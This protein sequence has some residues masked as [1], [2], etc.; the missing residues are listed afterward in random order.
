M[1]AEI[2]FGLKWLLIKGKCCNSFQKI[3]LD[4]TFHKLKKQRNKLLS[5]IEGQVKQ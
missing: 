1:S 4:F 5:V 3:G 2:V